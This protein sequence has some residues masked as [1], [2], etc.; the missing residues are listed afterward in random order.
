MD[1]SN[2]TK[3]VL[4]ESIKEL[5]VNESLDKIT[6]K[7]IVEKC[8]TTRQT[9]YRNFKD[10][11]D[12]VNW[13]FDQIVKKT[14][15]QMGISLTLKEGLI[16]KFEY[17]VEDKY[18]FMGALKSSDYN[19]LMDYDYKCICEFYKTVATSNGK[20]TP[21]I[22]YLIEFY[23]HGSMDMTAD[24]VKSGMKLTPC[25]MADLLVDAL[26]VKLKSYFD[27]LMIEK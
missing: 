7:E 5:L 21:Y 9:F 1:F 18:F 24:W 26:P 11:Y 16:K 14:I 25:Q 23:C 4:A 2:R 6:V 19:N 20:V 10:K 13:Y 3:W 12:L 8:G 15:K 22:E 27:T 17:M